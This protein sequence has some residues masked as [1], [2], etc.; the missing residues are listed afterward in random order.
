MIRKDG[1]I[2]ENHPLKKLFRRVADR[3]LTQSAIPD[4]DLLCYL[5]DLLLH[6]TYIEDLY[7]LKDESGKRL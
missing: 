5:S 6:F 3:A 2:P 7:A 4:K 1:K